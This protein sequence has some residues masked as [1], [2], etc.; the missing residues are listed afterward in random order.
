MDL[1][2]TLL[3]CLLAGLSH[4]SLAD[5]LLLKPGYPERYEVK[6][7]DTLW[8]IA[9]HYLNEPWRWPSLWQQNRQIKDPHW[10]Y[11]GDQLQLQWVNGQP[12]LQK[13]SH[14]GQGNIIRLSPKMR[15]E[16]PVGAIPTLPLS[17]MA[18]FLSGDQ[19]LEAEAAASAPYVL[20]SDKQHIGM[21]E[22]DMLY[23]QGALASAS[24]YGIYHLGEHYRDAQSNE[25]L[26]QAAV[27][28]GKA[29]V[30]AALPGERSQALLTKNLREVRQGDILLPL[31]AE[32]DLPVQFSPAAAPPLTGAYVVQFNNRAS[33]GGKYDVVLINRGAR[34]QLKPGDVLSIA[35]PAADV[36]LR[37]Q[38]PSYRD[39]ASRYERVFDSASGLPLP[40]TPIGQLMLFKVYDKLS[41]GLILHSQD[42]VG[43]GYRLSAVE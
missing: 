5:S 13:I 6:P 28:V 20:G 11:P 24:T 22:G 25:V 3:A 32:D 36:V 14:R 42:R 39:T 9:G 1:K 37:G 30:T 35:R 33:G 43:P 40:E 2:Q 10:I 7:G 23:V 27:L 8:A 26:G 38:T 16:S 15:I 34:E 29:R 12:Q 41:Y 18:P 4:A 17:V 19:V 31:P 21:L